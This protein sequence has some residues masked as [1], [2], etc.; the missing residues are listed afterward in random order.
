MFDQEL[1]FFIAHQDELVQ[2]FRGK[3]LVLRGENVEGVYD[4]PLEAYLCAQKQFPV[5]TFM[6]QPCQSGRSAYSVS[7]NSLSH[8]STR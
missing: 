8:D 4:S 5:G 3:I 2:K 6:I 7:I 1:A